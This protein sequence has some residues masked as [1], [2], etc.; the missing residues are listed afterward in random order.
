MLGQ[1]M[2]MKTKDGLKIRLAPFSKEDAQAFIT[3][4]GMNNA[5]SLVTYRRPQPQQSRTSTHGTIKSATTSGQLSGEFGILAPD[6][7]S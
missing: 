5:A 6:S 2:E 3:D 7:R 4:G 1:I